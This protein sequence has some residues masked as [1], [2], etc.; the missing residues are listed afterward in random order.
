[1]SHLHYFNTAA[2]GNPSQKVSRILQAFERIRN[3]VGRA[4]NRSRMLITGEDFFINDELANDYHTIRENWRGLGV[5]ARSLCALVGVPHEGL[6][7]VLTTGTSSAIELVLSSISDDSLDLVTTDFEHESEFRVIDTTWKRECRIVPLMRDILLGMGEAELID[8]IVSNLNNRSVLLISHVISTFGAVIPIPAL[9]KAVRATYKDVIIIVD[10]AHGPGNI[11]VDLKDTEVDVYVGS[12]HKWLR[13]P[14]TSGYILIFKRGHPLIA[15]RV[16]RRLIA[17]YSWFPGENNL[18]PTGVNVGPACGDC[19]VGTRYVLPLVGL[20][21]SINEL[22]ERG[23]KNASDSAERRRLTF[24]QF[25]RDF[26]SL[27]PVNDRISLRGS[28]I[29]ALALPKTNAGTANSNKET[30]SEVAIHLEEQ[31]GV[32]CEPVT[33]NLLRFSFCGD[34]TEDSLTAAVDALN[35]VVLS[36]AITS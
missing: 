32:V 20:M 13:G 16:K 11:A 15:E 36:E 34:E 10:G 3:G 21:T 9:V 29:C 30:T 23:V 14:E 4:S 26:S 6:D 22:F 28:A 8:R 31:F 35:S 33:N 17:A 2:I 18:L 7:V 12:G 1:M 27:V 5:L 25:V 24:E 19:G